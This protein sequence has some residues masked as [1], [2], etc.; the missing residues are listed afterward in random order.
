MRKHPSKAFT[1]VELLVVIGIIAI[2]IAMLMPALNRARESA[3]SVQCLSN[4]RQIGIGFFNYQASGGKVYPPAAYQNGGEWYTWYNVIMPETHSSG[5]T[6]ASGYGVLYC[7][8]G[9]QYPGSVA[10][11]NSENVSYGYNFIGLGGLLRE[12]EIR[13]IPGHY[14]FIYG[15]PSSST[16]YLTQPARLGILK[17]SSGVI[18]AFDC[19]IASGGKWVDW[20]RGITWNDKYNGVAVARHNKRCNILWADGHAT[21]VLSPASG[22]TFDALTA[23]LYQDSQGRG[24]GSLPTSWAPRSIEYPY[25]WS[26]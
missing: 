8:D 17:H 21:G 14:H 22:T 20:L 7:P 11:T 23:G 5:S 16:Y 4:L 18:V 6:Q 19:H 1:L 13:N 15:A 3:K 25:A 12:E 24:L 9:W 2:L 10:T 26:R